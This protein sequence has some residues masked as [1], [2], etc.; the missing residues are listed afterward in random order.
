MVTEV[1][2]PRGTSNGQVCQVLLLP[3]LPAPLALMVLATLVVPAAR[4]LEWSGL[5]TSAAT[6]HQVLTD[7]DDERSAVDML[8]GSAAV[9]EA[10]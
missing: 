3:A 6:R 7:D 4:S 5:S 2:G 1:I 8:C 10:V 9:S